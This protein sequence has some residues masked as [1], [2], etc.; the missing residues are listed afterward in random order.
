MTHGVQS[1]ADFVAMQ[2]AAGG[3]GADRAERARPL[4]ANVVAERQYAYS[5]VVGSITE[6]TRAI[7]FAGNPPF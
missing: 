1:A 4:I 2:Q 6:R 5:A 7:E 3:P